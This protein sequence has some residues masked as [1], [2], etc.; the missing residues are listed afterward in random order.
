MTWDW[1]A[2]ERAHATLPPYDPPQLKPGYFRQRCPC[3]NWYGLRSPLC[4]G[5]ATCAA[6]CCCTRVQL[7]APD[8]WV[9]AL[10]RSVH[11]S[12]PPEVRGVW[13]L[14]DHIQPTTLLTL[15]EAEWKGNVAHKRLGQNWIKA[16]TAY[17]VA[18]SLAFVI[19]DALGMGM[20]IERSPSG[21][22]MLASW[23]GSHRHWM[24]VFGE[25][26]AMQL[27]SG[28]KRVMAKGDILRIEYET[29]DDPSSPIT[30][31][32]TIE[33]VCVPAADGSYAYTP[34]MRE[35]QRRASSGETEPV[36]VCDPLHRALPTQLR[37]YQHCPAI[38]SMQRA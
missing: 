15:H 25:G 26:E 10:M 37:E 9:P 17:G 18:S 14:R 32:Y 34:A 2:W 31:M 1:D 30:Y 8:E 36:C 16:N 21:K 24:Y 33:R 38:A 12:S 28:A 13:W 19:G 3:L 4:F 22:W 35:L 23:G 6:D 20:R 11:P 29:W 5:C 27:P 7:T